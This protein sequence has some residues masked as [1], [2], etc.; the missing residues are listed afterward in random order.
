MKKI[1]LKVKQKIRKKFKPKYKNLGDLIKN[2]KI[3]KFYGL[4]AIK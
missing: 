2:N 1:Y 4:L 3:D